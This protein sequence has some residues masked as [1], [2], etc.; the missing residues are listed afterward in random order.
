ML[1]FS[2]VTKYMRCIAN[3]TQIFPLAPAYV[4][5]I[6]SQSYY[7]SYL[8]VALLLKTNNCTIAAWF[9]FFFFP[10]LLVCPDQEASATKDTAQ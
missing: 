4:L 2:I 1:L 3:H 10:K 8:F 6:T 7:S 5:F 9:S